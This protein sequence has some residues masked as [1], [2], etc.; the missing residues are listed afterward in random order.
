MCAELGFK[1]SWEG[2]ELRLDLEGSLEFER[3]EDKKAFLSA[4]GTTGHW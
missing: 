1:T 4:G 2:K 3:Q